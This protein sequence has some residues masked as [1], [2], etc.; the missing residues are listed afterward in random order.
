[1]RRT[2]GH[3]TPTGRSGRGGDRRLQRDRRG[4]GRAA[5]RRGLDGR[6]RGPQDGPLEDLAR[7]IAATGAAGRVFPPR[8]TSATCVRS[9]RSQP[10]CA[11]STAPAT[12][13]CATPGIGGGRLRDRDDLS[14]ALDVLDVNLAGTLRCC[15][16]FADLLTDSAPSQVINIASVAGKLGLGPA[17]YVASKFGMVGLS[18]ALGAAWRDRGITVT[19]LNPGFVHTEGFPQTWA[20]GTPAARLVVGPEVIAA[21]VSRAVA[22]T[23]RGGDVPALVPRV[24][25]PAPRRDPAVARDRTGRRRTAATQRGAARSAQPGQD[26]DGR[27]TAGRRRCTTRPDRR[28]RLRHVPTQPGRRR[29]AADGRWRRDGRHADGQREV[30]VLPGPRHRPREGP[31]SS[32]RR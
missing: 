18:E 4:D 10:R 32:S 9:T 3:E 21:A 14:D 2:A 25:R 5:R 13:W 16:A 20:D 8:S 11:A 30:P 31:G 29:R 15:A 1:M 7:S 17:A 23:Q 22:S 6:R 19:Q 24:R 26:R 28:V 27:I 12:C